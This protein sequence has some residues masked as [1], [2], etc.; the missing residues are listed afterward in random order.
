VNSDSE[1]GERREE[2]E[3]EAEWQRVR[4]ADRQRFTAE[5]LNPLR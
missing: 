2:T 4:L 1:R 3:R 5:V